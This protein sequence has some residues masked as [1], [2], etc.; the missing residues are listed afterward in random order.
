MIVSSAFTKDFVMISNNEVSL[1]DIH[2]NY[3]IRD[4]RTAEYKWF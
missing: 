4:P 2:Y 1:K 3:W